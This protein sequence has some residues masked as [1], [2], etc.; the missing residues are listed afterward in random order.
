MIINIRG[1]SGSGKTTL[2]R[3]ILE[4]YGSKTAYKQEGRKQP[5]GYVYRRNGEGRSLAVIGHYETA[6]GGCDTISKM[7]QIFE[8]VRQSHAAGHD[9]LFEGLL[10]S[11]DVNRTAALHT[12]GLPLLVV[13]LDVPLQTCLDSINI[14]RR[15]KN[16]DAPDVPSKNTESKHKGVKMSMK[17]LEADGVNGVTLDRDGAFERIKQEL[18]L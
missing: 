5:I 7:E 15:V 2:V 6:C 16:P 4:L 1:T 17:R 9:V 14:R 3:K 10:I 11:A 18:G 13:A 12:D 8:L